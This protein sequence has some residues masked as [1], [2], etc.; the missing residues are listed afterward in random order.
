MTRPNT[1]KRKQH[2]QTRTHVKNIYVI[3]HKNTKT[4][5]IKQQNN[6]LKRERNN[7]QRFSKDKP[8][9]TTQKTAENK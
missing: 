8:Y 3:P 2:S 9:T 7:T 5:L 1:L 6:K 4:N